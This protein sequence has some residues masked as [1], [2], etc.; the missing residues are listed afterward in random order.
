MTPPTEDFRY[1]P[2]HRV[3]P[4]SLYTFCWINLVFRTPF[5][6]TEPFVL[7]LLY[8]NKH[9]KLVQLFSLFPEGTGWM[10]TAKHW[11]PST[12]LSANVHFTAILQYLPRLSMARKDR[13]DLQEWVRNWWHSWSQHKNTRSG[14]GK[15]FC[16]KRQTIMWSCSFRWTMQQEC[17]YIFQGNPW[18]SIAYRRNNPF[19]WQSARYSGEGKGVGCVFYWLTWCSWGTS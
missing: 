2:K 12:A 3:F 17:E 15:N 10:H 16:L 19:Y 8:L 18:H 11:G 4:L 14:T 6:I 7:L 13:L 1:Y 9:T 5:D